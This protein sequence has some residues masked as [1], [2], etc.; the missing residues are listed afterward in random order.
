LV[1]RCQAYREADLGTS[2]MSNADSDA[3]RVQVFK[4]ISKTEKRRLLKE[5]KKQRI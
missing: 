1:K 2:K 4:H 3:W 5:V